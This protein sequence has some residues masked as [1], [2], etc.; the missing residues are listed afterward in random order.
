MHSNPLVWLDIETG[1]TDPEQHA[2]LEV[3]LYCRV[4]G[5]QRHTRA[6]VREPNINVGDAPGCNVTP[7]ALAVNK[8]PINLIQTQGKGAWE[9][10]SQLSHFLLSINQELGRDPRATFTLAGHNTQF[11][12]KFLCRLYRIAGHKLP[13]F[14]YRF[15]D[16]ASVLRFLVDIGE[17][18]EQVTPH[19][20]AQPVKMPKLEAGL[21]YFGIV[22]TLD[23]NPACAGVAGQTLEAHTALGDA[24]ATAELYEACR[25][26]LSPRKG[27]LVP[28]F[29]RT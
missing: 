8:I 10:A 29:S 19:A 23:P 18:P 28:L 12:H 25:N 17:L 24:I 3:A 20:G 1:G 6:Y 5:Q 27:G 9:V 4:N 15:L 7:G 21:A 11:D 13:P 22:P 26:L 2:V 14:E 16:T